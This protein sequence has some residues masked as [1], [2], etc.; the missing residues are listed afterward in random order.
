MK[1]RKLSTRILAY[2]LTLAILLSSLVFGA[3]NTVAEVPTD[4]DLWDGETAE[5]FANPDAAGTTA[6]P[7]IIETAEQLRYLVENYSTQTASENKVFKITKDI[8]L[9]N[10]VD[11]SSLIYLYGK[12]DWLADLPTGS[13][14]N[15]FCGTLDGDGHTIYGLY[16]GTA[17]RGGLFPALTSGAKIKNLSFNNILIGGGGYGGAITGYACW[18]STGGAVEITNCSVVNSIIGYDNNLQAAGGLIGHTLDC[19][20]TFTNCYSSD[21][22]LS[23]WDGDTKGF[24]GGFIGTAYAS[25][26][27]VKMINCYSAGNFICAPELS[28]IKCTNVYTNVAIPEGNTTAGIEVLDDAEMKGEK[29]KTFM[30][31]FDFKYTWKT[32]TNGYPVIRDEIIGVWDGD[33]NV[34]DY[35]LEGTGTEADPYLIKTAA[36]LAAVVTGNNGGAFTGKYFKLANDIRLNDTSSANW[37]ESNPHNWVWE[38]FRFIGTFDGDGHTIDGLY[39]KGG[40]RVMGLFSYVGADNNGVHK[41]TLKNFNMTNAYIES[42][43]A[44]GAGFAAGQASRV[45]YFDGIYIDSSCEINSTVTG[46][47][48][49]LGQSGYIFGAQLSL[50]SS[51]HIHT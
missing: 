35:N 32:V 33:P 7:Y 25:S 3:V 27:T 4:Y 22:S 10:V 41:T 18:D 50:P 15:S 44:D 45:A 14:A 47:G 36:Q 37:K 29:A 6:D 1:I 38:D 16:S 48:G 5:G 8:Y 13:K 26:G 40:Q 51:S 9:N 12:K 49:I 23:V 34:K 39:Y 2:T 11:G 30:P 46:A 21:V 20:V 42:S 28:K 19:T 24:P 43:A 31:G 17:S